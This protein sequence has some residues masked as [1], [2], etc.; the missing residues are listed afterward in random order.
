M[1]ITITL[2]SDL[3]FHTYKTA[4][5]V[6]MY[7]YICFYRQQITCPS[8]QM[9]NSQFRSSVNQQMLQLVLTCDH[10]MVPP[11]LIY[12][13]VLG[14]F[15]YLSDSQPCQVSLLDVESSTDPTPLHPSHP[16]TF[17]LYVTG[18]AKGSYTHNYKYLEIQY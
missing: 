3:P 6:Y 10:S 8:Y 11:H 13:V 5:H 4:I 17:P 15:S 2:Y 18:L 7:E 14:P 16:P 9:Y 1:D 12:S